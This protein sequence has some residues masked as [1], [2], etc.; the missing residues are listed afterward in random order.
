MLS[1]NFIEQH[2]I[3]PDCVLST[4]SEWRKLSPTQDQH[5]LHISHFQHRGEGVR[6][7]KCNINS[8]LYYVLICSSSWLLHMTCPVIC[9]AP[10][11]H[12]LISQS[13]S[14]EVF[15][16]FFLRASLI[17]MNYF[18]GQPSILVCWHARPICEVIYRAR[19]N[20]TRFDVQKEKKNFSYQTTVFY[21][22]VN[23]RF[24][25]QINLLYHIVQ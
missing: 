19:L 22:L 17:L 12:F 11:S 15:F 6:G 7:A 10:A 23:M 2:Q 9:I 4:T 20:I 13:L 1:V 8:P 24:Y 18:E 21:K 14:T 5:T 16:F 25:F 3:P